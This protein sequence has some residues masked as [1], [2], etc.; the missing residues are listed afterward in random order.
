MQCDCYE[1]QPKRQM[2]RRYP[3]RKV[4]KERHLGGD[5]AEEASRHCDL[6]N[7]ISVASTTAR[8]LYLFFNK[9]DTPLEWKLFVFNAII[10]AQLA[11][12]MDTVHLTESPCKELDVSHIKHL[13]RILKSH[14]PTIPGSLMKE[15]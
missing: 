7:R 1:Q 5:I 8:K 14:M 12:G 4:D 9:A 15:L 2:E 10:I 3:S 13:R 6:A 11:Y